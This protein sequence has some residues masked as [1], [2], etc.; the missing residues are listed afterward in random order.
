M[1]LVVSIGGLAVRSKIGIN[2]QR[3]SGKSKGRPIRSEK[4]VLV[5]IESVWIK[6]V[7]GMEQIRQ[8]IIRK[9]GSLLEESRMR[10]SIFR[11]R[12]EL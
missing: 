7:K 11:K 6:F 4:L 12:E 3:I 9:L 2:I 8:R 10:G 5:F 1:N